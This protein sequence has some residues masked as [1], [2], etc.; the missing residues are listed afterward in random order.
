MGGLKHLDFSRCFFAMDNNYTKKRFR[1][2]VSVSIKHGF[3]NGI[4]DPKELRL[5]LEELG[6]TFVK[7]G[8]ILSTRPDMLPIEYIDEFQKLQDEV[9]PGEFHIMKGVIESELNGPIEDIFMSFK[10]TPIASASLAEVYLA[11]LKTGEEVV[12][13]VQRPSVRE[14]MLSDIQILKKLAPFINFTATG[15]VVDMKEVIEELNMACQKE[16]NFVEEMK[17]IIRFSENNKNVKFITSPKVYEKYCTDKIL[18]M[19]YI[20]GIKIDNTEKLIEKGYDTHDIAAKLT[21]NYFKQVFED[22]F[23]HADPHPGNILIHENTI[24]YIDFGLMG[25]LDSNLRK[26]LNDFLEGAATK[27]IELMTKS[28]LKIGIKKGPIDENR[29]YNDIELMYNTYIDESIHDYD[30]PQILEEVV[31][32]CKKN[33]INMPKDITL[34]LKGMMTIQGVLA[35]IDKELT[36]MDI[37]MPYFKDQMVKDKFSNVDITEIIA[38]LYTSI[39]SSLALS[40]KALELINTGLSGRLKLNL[41]IKDMDE[42]F[43]EIN[44]MVNRLIFAIIVAGLLMSSS[45][46]INANVGLK[47]YGISAIGIVGY[48][49]A[50]LAGLLLL[51]S[52]FR[53]GKL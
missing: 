48:L 20:S 33:N 26:K 2:I 13:K 3:K 21:Y 28:I 15:E 6:P 27:D 37:A 24:G 14:K 10:E 8:Q 42:N 46:V 36:I 35:K 11:K 53:S 52:I 9:S 41:E 39:K 51:I 18:V 17:N 49:G 30:L 22:G 7:I 50:G 45:L 4:G 32:I 43:N 31:I 19:D 25:S 44:K 16:L 38:F 12:V 47:V 1:E 40:S 34:L 5:V 29:L 23:F